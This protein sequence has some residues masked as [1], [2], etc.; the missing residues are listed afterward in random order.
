MDGHLPLARS[1]LPIDTVSL[2]RY[3]IGKV[4]VRALPAVVSLK[5][6]RMSSATPPGTPTGG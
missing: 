4:L 5:R 2:A 3:L 1:E 6:R